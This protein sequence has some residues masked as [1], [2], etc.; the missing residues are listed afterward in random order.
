[1]MMM[2]IMMIV[3]DLLKI[4]LYG[5]FGFICCIYPQHLINNWQTLQFLKILQ[6][7]MMYIFVLAYIAG[8]FKEIIFIIDFQ[9]DE[10]CLF[11]T[12]E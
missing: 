9:K 10:R 3:N 2:M 7:N 5:I 1:M 8:N 4:T 6:W 11:N 12:S